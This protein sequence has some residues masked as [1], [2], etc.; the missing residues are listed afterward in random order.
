MTKF[1]TTI[2]LLLLT[3]TSLSQEASLSGFVE[4]Y[5][6]QPIMYA[7]ILVLNAEDGSVV[8]GVSSNDLGFFIVNDLDLGEYLV[9]ISFIGYKE[10]TFKITLNESKDLGIVTLEEASE[11]LD[12]VNILVKKP[13]LKKEPDR[14]VFNVES[15]ALVEGNML[16]L[17]KNTPGI[18]VVDNSILVKNTSPTVYINN[19]KVQLSSDELMQLLEGSSANSIK[20]VEVITNPSAK[21]DAE[22]GAVINIVMSKNLIAGYRGS[23]YANYEQGV[24]PRYQGG[25]NHFFKSE[26]INLFASYTYSHNKINRDDES[27]INYLNPDQSIDQIWKSDINRNT[28][29]KTHNFGFNFDYLID[30][31][32]TLSLSSTIMLL[33]YYRYKINNLTTAFDGSENLD[34]Y[35]GSNNFSSDKKHN[36]G[37]DLGYVHR[38]KKEG[39]QLSANVHFTSYDFERDQNVHSD[40]FDAGGSFLQ[41]SSFRTNNNQDNKI[42][43]AQ[44]DYQLPMKDGSTLETG[45]KSSVIRSKSDIS[46]FNIVDDEETIDPN[47]TD[48]FDYDESIFAGYINY[49]KNWEKLSFVAGLRAEQTNIKGVSVVD[50]TTN[51]QDY[52]EWFPTAS[53]SYAFSDNF[54]LYGNYKRSISRPDYQSLNPFRFFLNDVTIVTGNPALKPVFT[55][56]TVLGTSLYEFFTFEAYHKTYKNNFFELPRQ[57]NIDNTFVYTPSNIEKTTE[58]GFDFL[59]NFEMVRRWSVYFVTSFYNIEDQSVFDGVSVHQSQWSNFSSWSNDLTFLKDNSLSVSLTLIYASKNLQGFTISKDILISDLSLSKSILKK[60]ASIFLNVSDIFN[61]QDYRM[62]NRYLNQDNY[63]ST[64]IDSRFVKLGFRYNFGNTNLE[65]NRRTIDQEETERLEKKSL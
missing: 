64:D 24:F 31:Q 3:I 21:Y 16:Q 47:N 35:F 12:E 60:K 18:L 33:P 26:K 51:K 20:S 10:Q 2:S 4:D 63:S 9:R 50:D 15:T 57:N 7:N 32:N 39:E 40:Y 28:W 23:I 52:L 41:S 42:F 34:F 46:Q 17:I 65:T 48:A 61:T 29:T 8:K 1:L 38:F 30:S 59:F 37:F 55:S 58:Y 27:I 36:M 49:N 45:I 43:T 53:L 6:K 13:T 5:E 11:A 54:T 62:I 56:H 14:L 22:S 25:M 19:R 44:I